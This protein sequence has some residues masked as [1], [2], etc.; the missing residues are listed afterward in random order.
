MR[1]RS[2]SGGGRRGRSRRRSRDVLPF[3]ID[4]VARCGHRGGIHGRGRRM[5]RAVVLRG[6]RLA[7]LGMRRRRRLGVA[8]VDVLVAHAAAILAILVFHNHRH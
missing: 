4:G 2:S 8:L 1:R 7:E 3:Y 6:P 5:R